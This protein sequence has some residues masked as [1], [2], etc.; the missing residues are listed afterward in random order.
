MSPSKTE[1]LLAEIRD[2]LKLQQQEARKAR[3]HH[4][5][6]LGIKVAFYLFVATIAIYSAFFYVSTLTTMGLL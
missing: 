6:G 1:L 4:A 3:Q 2:L 5:I